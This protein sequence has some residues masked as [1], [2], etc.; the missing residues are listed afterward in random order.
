MTRL[1]RNFA[2]LA[3][4]MSGLSAPMQAGRSSESIASLID[5]VNAAKQRYRLR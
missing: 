4:R 3:H 5:K 2:A 1:D